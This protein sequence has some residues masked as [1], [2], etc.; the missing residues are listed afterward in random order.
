MGEKK[1]DCKGLR[2][3]SQSGTNLITFS[4]SLVVRRELGR[5]PELVSR[6]KGKRSLEGTPLSTF[7]GKKIVNKRAMDISPV[8]QRGWGAGDVSSVRRQILDPPKQ[9]Y[10][11]QFFLNNR[12]FPSGNPYSEPQY[13]KITDA[14]LKQRR[15]WK[16]LVALGYQLQAKQRGWMETGWRRTP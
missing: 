5:Q 13:A 16:A 1:P 11:K 4:L 15:S 8:E 14:E 10:L 6:V 12:H 3:Q 2:A 9:Y 7:V